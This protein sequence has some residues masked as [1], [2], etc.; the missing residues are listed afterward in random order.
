VTI[1]G[2]TR[3]YFAVAAATFRQ[4]ST[5]RLAAVAGLTANC[6]FGIIMAI[7]FRAALNERGE[8]RTRSAILDGLTPRTIVTYTFAA[9]AIAMV[10]SAF[11]D[12][13]L[14]ARVRSGD[15][16]TDLGRPVDFSLFRLAHDLGRSSYHFL[17]R[18][19]SVMS[20]GWLVFR[21]PLPTWLSVAKFVPLMVLAAA[22]AS[23]LWTMI[24][25][26]SFWMRDGT[27]AVQLM[28]VFVAFGTGGHLPLQFY[29]PALKHLLR[30]LPFASMMQ[31]PCGVLVGVESFLKVAAMQ[32]FWLVTLEVLLRVELRRAR[33]R[34]ELNG[35]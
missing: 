24:G 12:Y 33:A 18:G 30:V 28:V 9:Q 4:F 22:I 23:R 8:V 16:A 11:G 1:R 10:V 19:L 34:L 14:A 6:T 25:L 27:G 20:V 13:A 15:I 5:Y 35:G 31:L 29:P 7:T 21:F 17:A 2:E 26:A 32:V 3:A